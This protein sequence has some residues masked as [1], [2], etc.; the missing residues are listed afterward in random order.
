MCRVV[1][2][3]VLCLSNR[4]DKRKE[5]DSAGNTKSAKGKKKSAKKTK[6]KKAPEDVDM[7]GTMLAVL[8][9]CHAGLLRQDDHH[10]TSID[11]FCN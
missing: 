4:A 3:H 10:F 7:Q 5:E 11:G 9:V 1:L 6:S 2:N 8:E